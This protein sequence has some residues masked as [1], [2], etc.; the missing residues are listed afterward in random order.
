M[1][2][3]SNNSKYSRSGSGHLI[4]NCTVTVKNGLLHGTFT[5]VIGQYSGSYEAVDGIYVEKDVPD[6]LKAYEK[7]GSYIY[8]VGYDAEGKV[9]QIAQALDDDIK[10]GVNHFAGECFFR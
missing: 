6:W 7:E 5:K 4:S 9:G 8:W 3:L 1:L 2:K 10:Q